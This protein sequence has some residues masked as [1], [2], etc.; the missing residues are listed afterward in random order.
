MTTGDIL[1][2]AHQQAVFFREIVNDRRDLL[3]SQRDERLKPALAAD[4]TVLGLAPRAVDAG[5]LDGLLET[6]LLDAVDDLEKLLSV[7]L[8][9]IEDL[10]PVDRDKFDREAIARTHHRATSEMSARSAMAKK[11][12]S[13]SNRKASN[14]RPLSSA[15]RRR[16]MSS[17]GSGRR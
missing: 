3:L 5:Y 13:V 8:P 15:S 9:G 12:S 16:F 2:Q 1:H 6:D 14:V 11:N 17:T 10:D 7:A 4:Q